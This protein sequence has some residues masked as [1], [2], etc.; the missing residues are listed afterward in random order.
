MLNAREILPRIFFSRDGKRLSVV[1]YV[2]L[3]LL[4]A[5][6]FTPGIVSMPPTD[7]DKSSFAQATK[8]MIETG[9]YTD[10]R[11]QDTPRYKKPIGIYWLQSAS[12]R[13]LDPEHL[14]EIWAYRVPSFIGA[15]IAVLMTAALGALLFSPMT[16]LLGATMLAGCILLNVE[17]RLAKTDAALL[18]SI[19]VA[20]YA[21]ARTYLGTIPSSKISKWCVPLALW[22]AVAVGVLIKGPILFLPI[23]GIL[24]WVGISDKSISW[25]KALR[26]LYGI[27]FALAL[28]APWFIAII[29]QSHG[30]FMQQSAG[31]DM[32][33]KI[34]QGQNRGMMPPGMHLLALPILF[35]PF[36]LFAV[37]AVPDVWKN[38]RET[39]VKFCLGWI[40][41]MW[42]V[43]ELSMTKL[44]HYVLPAYPAI[45]LLTA[46][47]LVQGFPSVSGAK[48]RFPLALV[49]GMWLVIGSAFAF[50]FCV[51]PYLT[52]GT[53]EIPQIAA[54]M[55]LVAVQGA[56]LV[57]FLKRKTASLALLTLS[58][59]V[60]LSVTFG[61]TIPRLQ[62]V[63][64]SREIVDAVAGAWP[65][66]ET[67]TVSVGYHEPS[68]AFMAG[69]NTI[70]AKTGVEAAEA[71]KQ[72]ACR[73][74]VI[75]DS[76]KQEF[77]DAFAKEKR[78][79][80]KAGQIEG[81]NSGRGKQTMLTVFVRPAVEER[82]HK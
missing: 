38:R 56:A 57:I 32:L 58:S 1:S 71:L 67:Q 27:P 47:Y 5:A 16:G 23:L 53:L 21:M 54:G 11:L 73:V 78:K 43:F 76:H 44:A 2:F 19:M 45:A 40:I 3:I 22:T 12:V 77:I 65:C 50:L 36:S 37:F 61:I 14:N 15:T 7:R 63:W 46:H 33:A 81:L 62:H 80:Q 48:H 30:A 25:F 17:A 28:I 55:F 72:D 20:V 75:D 24:L 69:T 10:I 34:W 74:V 51:L 41:P 60:F 18:A 49:V 8:Q 79:P 52:N 29:L 9:N 31:N 42:I 70:M 66:L 35:F 26:P 59:L 4:C 64:M 82:R 68:L 39:A 6:F 13:L